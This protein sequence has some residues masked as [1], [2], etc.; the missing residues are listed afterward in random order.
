MVEVGDLERGQYERLELEDGRLA[1]GTSVLA[2]F[3]S[4]DPGIKKL[5]TLGVDDPL[6]IET[7]T[8]ESLKPEVDKQ[9]IDA[10]TIIVNSSN[11]NER[12]F[13]HQALAA[14]RELR[15]LYGQEDFLDTKPAPIKPTEDDGTTKPDPR[16]RKVD[17]MRPSAPK[18]EVDELEGDS[19][20]GI[21][22]VG[23]TLS[24][25]F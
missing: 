8:W 18:I 11:P 15:K 14:L 23:E 25:P 2:L 22:G 6:D 19:D 16:N 7:N 17:L 5:I 4:N 9:S 12:W 21:K 20:D 1:D 13:A 3:H 10:M 24:R